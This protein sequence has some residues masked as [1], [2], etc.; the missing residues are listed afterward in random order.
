MLEIGAFEAK[1][2]LPELLRMVKEKGEEI[3]I[4]NRGEP[5][6]KLCA[7]TTHTNMEDAINNLMKF[8]DKVSLNLGNKSL[9]SLI[10]EG[11][12]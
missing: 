1:N 11:R 3:I 12:K 8:G 9:K 10:E 7:V 6:A 5:M 4:T 2:K